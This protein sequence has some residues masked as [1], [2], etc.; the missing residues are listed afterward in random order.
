MSTLSNAFSLLELDVEDDREETTNAT[1]NKKKANG[2][3]FSCYPKKHHLI[4]H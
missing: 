2:I 1:D 3:C 4:I